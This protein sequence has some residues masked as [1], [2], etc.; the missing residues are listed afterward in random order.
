[1]TNAAKY[2]F[3]SRES[4]EIVVGY[5]EDGAGWRLWVQDDG[6]GLPQDYR[7]RDRKSFG[8]LLLA[9]LAYR[10]NAELNFI[11][12]GGTRVEVSC[13]VTNKRAK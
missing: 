2:A 7:C 5:R 10:V 9:T 11:C 1:M 8:S 12:E 6:C 13:G 4:G 3:A